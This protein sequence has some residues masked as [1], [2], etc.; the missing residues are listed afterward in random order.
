[1]TSIATNV[2]PIVRPTISIKLKPYLQDYIQYLMHLDHDY[3]DGEYLL[4]TTTSYLGRLVSPFISLRPLDE[5]PF[6]D[7]DHSSMFTFRIINYRNFNTR[8]HTAWISPANQKHIEDIVSQHF[9]LTFR[10][11]ADD[12]IRYLLQD[13]GSMK[14][15]LK[16]VVLQFCLDLNIDF[17]KISFE[18]LCKSYW[19]DRKITNFRTTAGNLFPRIGELYFLM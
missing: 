12:K 4:A 5:N 17:D 8:H 10:L 11:Y 2:T 6:T 13:G 18:L 16:N 3:Q 7:V 14:G 15:A 19:R 1:M 9:R